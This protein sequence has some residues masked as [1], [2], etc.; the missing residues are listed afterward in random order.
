[1]FQPLG[2]GSVA[3]TPMRA[4]SEAAPVLKF[5]SCVRGFVMV[6]GG[7]EVLAAAF[8]TRLVG[9]CDCLLLQAK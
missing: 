1:M 2:E 9:A 6:P 5:I 8:A 7:S 4:A 3:L